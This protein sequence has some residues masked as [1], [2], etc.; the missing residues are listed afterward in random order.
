MHHGEGTHPEKMLYVFGL[1]NPGK[2]YEHTRHNIG[3][4]LVSEYAAV[5]G[6]P[7]EKDR[8]AQALVARGSVRGTLVTFVLPET[9]M[10]RSGD[11]ASYFIKKHGAAPEQF[12]VVHDE[13]DL[14]LGTVR[15][16][17]NRGDGGHNGVTSM[18]DGTGSREFA[19]IR[20]GIAPTSFWTGKVKRPG[21]GGALEKFV[22]GSFSRAERAVMREVAPRVRGA[23]ETIVTEGVPLAMNRYN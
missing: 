17:T 14:P 8:N 2:E 5:C 23:V 13:I 6:A 7:W 9:Y 20:I 15:I 3:R 19:R 10:N 22:L 1:G 4:A 16:G 11:T 12:I 18:I 21:G